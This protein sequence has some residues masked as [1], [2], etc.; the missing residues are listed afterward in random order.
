MIALVIQ[1]L[2]SVVSPQFGLYLSLC[3]ATSFYK[4]TSCI[5]LLVI[6]S[7]I[8][9]VSGPEMSLIIS[10]VDFGKFFM[11]PSGFWRTLMKPFI[12]PSG[13]SQMFIKSRVDSC[14]PYQK[15]GGFSQTSYQ[16]PSGFS[17][18]FI[19]SRV[20]SRKSCTKP[21]GFCGN[22]LQ[23]PVNSGEI[24]YKTRWISGKLS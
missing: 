3:Q 11:K 4:G 12:K 21:S 2:V 1:N 9:S 16:K 6:K 22:L 23:N 13:F 14:E 15:S 7:V 24:F 18:I 19:K 5:Y 20:D 17:Q 8:P 10:P